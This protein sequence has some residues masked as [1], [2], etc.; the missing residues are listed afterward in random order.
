MAL[1][2]LQLDDRAAHP[3]APEPGGSCNPRRDTAVASRSLLYG[4]GCHDV[5]PEQADRIPPVTHVRPEQALDRRRGRRF[6]HRRAGG[7]SPSSGGEGR[8]ELR[9]DS[10]RRCLS[11]WESACR[12]FNI[13]CKYAGS[14]SI[15]CA[16][17]IIVSGGSNWGQASGDSGSNLSDFPTLLPFVSHTYI[18]EVINLSG[19]NHTVTGT[20]YY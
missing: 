15:P 19:G 8:L 18:A 4:E 1:L 13:E 17:E 10:A 3:V 6:A 16:A 11:A 14:P 7:G 2:D 12:L 9:C 20:A 5:G